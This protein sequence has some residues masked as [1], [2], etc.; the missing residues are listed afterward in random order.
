MGFATDIYLLLKRTCY[1]GKYYCRYLYKN[2][3]LR[4]YLK[5]RTRLSTDNCIQKNNQTIIVSITTYPAREKQFLITLETIMR[6]TFKPDRVIVWLAENQYPD[7][8][9]VEYIYRPFLQR[10]LEVRYCDDLR[11]H[12]KYYYTMLEN[13]NAVIITLDDDVYYP[14]NTIERLLSKYDGSEGIII[15]NMARYISVESGRI[16]PYIN[17]RNVKTLNEEGEKML[18]P[19]GVGGVL[20]APRSLDYRAFNKE[21]I[22]SLC[23]HTDD[24]WLNAMARLNKSRIICLGDF[25]TL[26]TVK[27]SQKSSL[28]IDNVTRNN[29]E[30]A[31][32]IGKFATSFGGYQCT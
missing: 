17:W 2:T 15:A 19:I 4:L 3:V 24:L 21:D 28:G 30:L 8:E 16:Q 9:R 22:F 27:G 1:A 18:C 11:S 10:G 32:I 5:M 29:K 23:I 12:K 13:P 26:I 25:E 14:P 20:Y 7:R 6:Q 31:L